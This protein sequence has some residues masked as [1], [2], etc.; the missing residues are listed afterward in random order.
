[1]FGYAKIS[2][3]RGSIKAKENIRRFDIAVYQ[4][5]FMHHSQTTGHLLQDVQSA[6]RVEHFTLVLRQITTRHIFHRQVMATIG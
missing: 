4:A 5:L 2:D 6:G 3:H 1:L